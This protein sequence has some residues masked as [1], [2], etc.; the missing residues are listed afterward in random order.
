MWLGPMWSYA[1]VWLGTGSNATMWLGPLWSY[2]TVWLGPRSNAAGDRSA[3]EPCNCVATS[4]EQCNW[5]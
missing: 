1:T 4:P 5:G 3:V 2:A